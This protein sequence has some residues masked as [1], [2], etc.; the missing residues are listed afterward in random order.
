MDYLTEA[1]TLYDIIGYHWYSDMGP[2]RRDYQNISDVLQAVIDRYK[3]PV[4]ITETNT[5]NGDQFLPSYNQSLYINTTLNT[6]LSYYSNSVQAYFLY[7]LIDEMQFGNS[8]GEAHY[9]LS[10]LNPQQRLEPKPLAENYRQWIHEY[11][12]TVCQQ[13]VWAAEN[14]NQ[15]ICADQPMN[16]GQTPTARSSSA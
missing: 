15:L 11:Q 10:R 13:C 2:L 1:A 3:K 8:S 12:Q 9:G 5:K 14:S 7:E 4:W 6:I 16:Q